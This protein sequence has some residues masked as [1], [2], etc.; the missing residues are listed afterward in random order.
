[1]KPHKE[2]IWSDFIG[3]LHFSRDSLLLANPN[4]HFEHYMKIM[5]IHWLPPEL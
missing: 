1:M 4:Y 3:K 2:S 5:K